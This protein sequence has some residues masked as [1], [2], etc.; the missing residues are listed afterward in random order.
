MAYFFYFSCS[1]RN[2][3]NPISAKDLKSKIV[4]DLVLVIT[5]FP[6]DCCIVRSKKKSLFKV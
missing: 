6:P 3:F 1:L 5:A 2:F 4:L